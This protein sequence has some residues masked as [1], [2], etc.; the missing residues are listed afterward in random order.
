[1]V[2]ALLVVV[3]L[4]SPVETD[5]SHIFGALDFPGLP[6][7]SQCPVPPPAD[8][9]RFAGGTCRIRNAI[10]SRQPATADWHSYLG[11]GRQATKAP[12]TQARIMLFLGH[13]FQFHPVVMQHLAGFFIQLQVV[14]GIGERATD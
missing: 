1:M 2:N 13:F 4:R 11:T 6:S 3:E 12:V 9:L 8:H 10:R 5:L 7:L 14:D